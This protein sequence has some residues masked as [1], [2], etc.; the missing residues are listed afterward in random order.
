MAT[1]L[2]LPPYCETVEVSTS[3]AGNALVS[4]ENAIIGE[5]FAIA[6]DKGTVNGATTAVITSENPTLTLDSYNVNDGTACRGIGCQVADSTDAFMPIPVR[7]K[8]TIK[9]SG[10]AASKAFT[11]YVYYR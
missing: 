10:G 11:V 4:T 7:G 5:I 9:V 3:A 1:K 8:L 6:Y 2:G